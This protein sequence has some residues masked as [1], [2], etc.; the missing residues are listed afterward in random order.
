MKDE[1]DSN[2][3]IYCQ[4]SHYVLS[5]FE[6]PK[7]QQSPLSN[8]LQY[9]FVRQLGLASGVEVLERFYRIMEISLHLCCID[10]SNFPGI[11]SLTCNSLRHCLLSF[12]DPYSLLSTQLATSICCEISHSAR[13]RTQAQSQSI[14]ISN[15]AQTVDTY[16]IVASIT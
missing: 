1:K 15:Q 12:S 4:C 8:V 2:D 7:V 11:A 10:F 14:E 5:V 13:W 16:R 9:V 3:G 6:F